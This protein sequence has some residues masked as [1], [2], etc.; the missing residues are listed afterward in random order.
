MGATFVQNNS[1]LVSR[2]VSF[3]AAGL[4]LLTFRIS[5]PCPFKYI[6]LD[7]GHVISH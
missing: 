5:V 3:D 2:I 1:C 7:L 6:E 4:H